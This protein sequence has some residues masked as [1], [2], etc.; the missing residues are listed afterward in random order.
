MQLRALL[1][2]KA[3][4]LVIDD[5]WDPN[6]IHPFLVGS[7]SCRIL[8]TTRRADIASAVGATL[9]SMNVMTEAEA[10]QLF[11][12]RLKRALDPA[13]TKLAARLSKA[14]G[15]LPLAL[16]QAAAR[17]ERG[18]AWITL[19]EGL[20]AEVARLEVL[21]GPR[22]QAKLEASFNLSIQALQE[23][24]SKAWLAFVWLGVLPED[25]TIAAPMV[26]TLWDS[27]LAVAEEILEL[28]WN[29]ALILPG[30]PVLIDQRK[31]PGYR[32]HDILH[33]LARKAIIDTL[34]FS[35][36]QA[37]Q[38]LLEK[39][40]HKTRA[41]LWYTIPDDGYIY[42]H[43]TWHLEKS[44]QIQELH[45]LFVQETTEGGNGW[46][47]VRD[48][49]GQTAGYL[50]DLERAWQHAEKGNQVE[51]LVRY[52]L[53]RATMTS[54]ARNISPDLLSALVLSGIW[55]PAK[56][57]AYAQQK[58][59]AKKG[60]EAL[61]RI[62]PHL[63]EVDQEAVFDSIAKKLRS[64]KDRFIRSQLVVRL[65]Q[66]LPQKLIAP[67]FS[68]VNEVGDF[69]LLAHLSL[70]FRMP[71]PGKPL[72]DDLFSTLLREIK[73]T[74]LD[75]NELAQILNTVIPGLSVQQATE[76][77]NLQ[78]PLHLK[79]LLAQF[80]TPGLLKKTM[81]S[82]CSI[83]S[84]YYRAKTFS[85]LIPY[86]PKIEQ[87]QIYAE[88]MKITPR[89]RAAALGILANHLPEP[90]RQAVIQDALASLQAMA[91]EY[92]RVADFSEIARHLSRAL[93]L[94]KG[95][96]IIQGYRLPD[97]RVRATALLINRLAELKVSDDTP[98][99]F[100]YQIWSDCK[101]ILLEILTAAWL[102]NDQPAQR[103]VL[104]TIITETA[105]IG[106]LNVAL[107]FIQ[108]YRDTFKTSEGIY[109]VA[110]W[111]AYHGH[112]ANAIR[113]T[114]NLPLGV[115][116]QLLPEILQYIDPAARFEVFFNL[117]AKFE[118]LE[119]PQRPKYEEVN[120]CVDAFIGKFIRLLCKS[121]QYPLALELGRALH[122]KNGDRGL[123]QLALSLAN[124]SQ[125]E[126]A[127]AI[128][129]MIPKDNFPYSHYGV[130]V[131]L[132]QQTAGETRAGLVDD[133]LEILLSYLSRDGDLLL[134]RYID[135][136][137]SLVLE[138]SAYR[139]V[140]TLIEG[141]SY[142]EL[143][144]FFQRLSR[145]QVTFQKIQDKPAF[146]YTL[147]FILA[148]YCI[149]DHPADIL[150]LLDTLRFVFGDP[151]RSYPA[152]ER[153]LKSILAHFGL[154]TK[155]KRLWKTLWIQFPELFQ[156]VLQANWRRLDQFGG[157]ESQFFELDT[158]FE[159]KIPPAAVFAAVDSGAEL[160]GAAGDDLDGE[161]T[162]DEEYNFDEDVPDDEDIADYAGEH[163][164]DDFYYASGRAL[165][166]EDWPA[167]TSAK[168]EP[169]LKYL[170]DKNTYLREISL[171]S[172]PQALRSIVG[173]VPD[174]IDQTNSE[175]AE[176]LFNLILK[177]CT[178]WQ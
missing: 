145:E 172:R 97:T 165:L 104:S 110:K 12:A 9:V 163:G 80:F 142:S 131:S 78:L 13:E 129:K 125:V 47:L 144:I 150:G 55:T 67:T 18:V 96:E 88:L 171:L 19:C 126:G 103:L 148:R 141:F 161:D 74:D 73:R 28:L 42:A 177:L 82:A 98:E 32:L 64:I 1:H 134:A 123:D 154:G 25:V 95:A 159:A 166:E 91:Y 170:S 81:N 89:Y 34:G 108:R 85:A 121:E 173:I 132:V 15:Y 17:L 164:S 36:P 115:Q 27:S 65:S 124:A 33:D 26:A 116:T 158:P 162:G 84:D 62:L 6:H 3:C 29:D 113:M 79:A 160:E 76:M 140:E 151:E 50:E 57:L 174:L 86:L 30:T 2:D 69:S 101:A 120:R 155:H 38:K 94:E 100:P 128:L 102:I 59:D 44:S 7:S 71:E 87:Q 169:P 92:K 118:A 77:I 14:T 37:N 61:A 63:A 24:N 4:L 119:A 137:F 83:Q 146:C 152:S 58:Q 139:P 21:Y 52:A 130:V 127:I 39:Y 51:L 135:P 136:N 114:E 167:E 45:D 133:A 112:G 122:E 40:R 109:S 153:D 16:E 147:L 72:N 175:L 93:I 70:L 149:L 156:V 106:Q 75:E 31:W 157:I 5:V 23:Y 105:K 66:L 68:L 111:L 49:A 90:E 46:F 48:Q 168:P 143:S 11:S 53:I 43:L 178:W 35:M 41:G 117:L 99:Q 176:N 56:G 22:Q 8:I 138:Q 20:E 54:L 107:N 10:L 60:I